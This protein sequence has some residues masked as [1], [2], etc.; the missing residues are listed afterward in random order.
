LTIW[1]GQLEGLFSGPHSE[2][3]ATKATIVVRPFVEIE[4]IRLTEQRAPLGTGYGHLVEAM[5]IIAF[6]FGASFG[7]HRHLLVPQLEV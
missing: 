1:E 4:S 7:N 5:V 2:I 6:T 3:Y